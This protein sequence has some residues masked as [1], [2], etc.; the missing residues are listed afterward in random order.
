MVQRSEVEKQLYD[1]TKHLHR[2]SEGDLD[3]I[4]N[5]ECPTR[6]VRDRIDVGFATDTA[7]DVW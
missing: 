7:G 6:P 2:P 1:A 5:G 3:A 4:V